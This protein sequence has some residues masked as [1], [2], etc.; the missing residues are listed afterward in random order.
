MEKRQIRKGIYPTMITPFKKDHELDKEAIAEIVRFYLVNGI[1]GVFAVCQSSEMFFLSLE[2]R[3]ALAAEVVKQNQRIAAELKKEPMSVVVSGHTSPTLKAQIEEAKRIYETGAD[4]FVL[5]SN[6]LDPEREGD[7]VFKKNTETFLKE[8]EGMPLGIYECPYPYK[9]LLSPDLLKWCESTGRFLF[10]KDTCCD[11][12]QLEAKIKVV[13]N[14]D[15]Y[16]FNAN[17][18]TLLP[19]LRM[20]AAGFSGVMANFHPDLYVRLYE[21]YIR[22][23]PMA[24]LLQDFLTF[25]ALSER[26][27]YPVTAKYHMNL[28]GIPMETITRARPASDL[29]GM[30][31]LETEALLSVE[32]AIRKLIES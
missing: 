21:M 26:S 22:H 12:E 23:D 17:A 6:R 9:R 13:K 18:Q 5:V 20:G 15:M 2:E 25:G 32:N 30:A 11:L 10:M 31:K 1:Q 19:S 3:I 29:D 8:T 28:I 16:L 27:A 7:T 4:A 14:S 24:E